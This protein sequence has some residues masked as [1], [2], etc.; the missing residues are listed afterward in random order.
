MPLRR[1]QRLLLILGAPASSSGLKYGAAMLIDAIGTGMVIPV[2]IIYL[3]SAA[4]ITPA[5]SAYYLT[6]I[7][8]VSMLGMPIG[9]LLADKFGSKKVV[10]A[11]LLLSSVCFM[12]L[13]L[14]HNTTV[15]VFVLS[16]ISLLDRISKAVKI[17]FVTDFSHSFDRQSTLA[18]SRS[19]RNGGYA[20]G[21]LLSSVW[22]GFS[23]TKL[24]WTLFSMN[25][26]TFLAALIITNSI[27]T[28]RHIPTANEEKD[29]N[30]FGVIKNRKYIVATLLNTVIVALTPIIMFGIPFWIGNLTTFPISVAPALFSINAI[31]VFLIQPI[32]AKYV[33]TYAAAMQYYCLAAFIYAGSFGL[34]LLSALYATPFSVYTLIAGIA[35]LS[36]GEVVTSSAEFYISIEMAPSTQIGQYLGVFGLGIEIQRVFG[37][38]IIIWILQGLGNGAWIMMAMSFFTACTLLA[39][40][41]RLMMRQTG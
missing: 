38:A 16:T 11:S 1:L 22:L 35:V 31:I 26:A 30:F 13:S 27:Q 10:T 39:Y 4:S 21:G 34:I 23:D 20:F 8:L 28:Y 6:I 33:Q 2:I 3:T 7:G 18:F 15:V 14:A 37:P 36:L 24:I 41:C 25:S 17:A 12:I 29:Y 5:K 40:L 32:V 19:M 9:G